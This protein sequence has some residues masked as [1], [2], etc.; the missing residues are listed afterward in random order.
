VWTAR[1]E[2]DSAERI[3][4]MRAAFREHLWAGPCPLR[5]EA[6]LTNDPELLRQAAAGFAVIDARFE[7]ACTLTLLDE[8]S[9]RRG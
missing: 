8:A 7:E 6:R 9:S 3:I 1:G 4:E 5:A 2:P